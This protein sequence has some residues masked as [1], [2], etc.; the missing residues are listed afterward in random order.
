MSRTVYVTSPVA[1]WGNRLDLDLVCTLLEQNGFEVTRWP[2]ADRSKKARLT[3]VAKRIFSGRGRFDLNLFLAPIFPEWIP[4]ARKS[5]LIPNAEGFA[6]ASWL[7]HIDLVLAKTRLTERI[8]QGLGCRTEFV[9]F[10]SED[11][12][13]E[14]V[15]RDETTFFHSCSSQYKGTQ[16]TLETWQRHPEWPLLT[17]VVNHNELIPPALFTG[18]NIRVI[19]ERLPGE[20]LRRLQNSHGYHL[21][22]SEAE[23]FGHYIMEAMSC[24]ALPFTSDGPPMNE[25][26]QPDRGFLVKCEDERPAMRFSQR[27]IIR[28][29]GLEEQVER[30]IRLDAATKRTMGE[31]GRAFFLEKDRFFR[32]RFIEVMKAL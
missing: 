2:A 26:V 24:R 23:G 1:G 17:A 9:S 7:K 6:Q 29:D 16:R 22:C 3:N 25:L 14:S 30:A 32:Q 8:F 10:T 21:C 12:L 20:E 18:P 27:H 4:L 11:H 15:P 28:G 31:A 13:D 5:V 19:R